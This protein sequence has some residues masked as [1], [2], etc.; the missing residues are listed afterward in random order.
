MLLRLESLAEA[1]S[2]AALR[3][4]RTCSVAQF[5]AGVRFRAAVLFSHVLKKDLSSCLCLYSDVSFHAVELIAAALSVNVAVLLLASPSVTTVNS[6]MDVLGSYHNVIIVADA[7]QR[8]ALLDVSAT[9]F[10]LDA[11]F[12]NS[13]LGR[14]G[15]CCGPDLDFLLQSGVLS[16]VPALPS[17]LAPASLVIVESSGVL[18][19]TSFVQLCEPLLHV[20]LAV[21]PAV[22]VLVPQ[23]ALGRVLG[24]CLIVQTILCGG[25]LLLHEGGAD[26]DVTMPPLESGPSCL[27]LC[28]PGER[29]RNAVEVVISHVSECGSLASLYRVEDH[30]LSGGRTI[31]PVAVIL[32][33]ALRFG[34][35]CSFLY[36]RPHVVTPEHVLLTQWTRNNCT[37]SV[38]LRDAEKL[39][40][41]VFASCSAMTLGSQVP[42]WCAADMVAPKLID[43]SLL[44][45]MVDQGGLCLGSSFQLLQGNAEICEDRCRV[46][47]ARCSEFSVGLFNAILMSPLL[48]LL[49]LE[50]S[51][52]L[53]LPR[54]IGR[55][56]LFLEGVPTRCF[57]KRRSDASFDV[58]AI[59]AS[60]RVVLK[61]ES[62][63]F[64]PLVDPLSVESFAVS[65]SQDRSNGSLLGNRSTTVTL[66]LP[67]RDSPVPLVVADLVAQKQI[68]LKKWGEEKHRGARKG[69]F[70]LVAAQWSNAQGVC[71]RLL[72]W[73]A[74]MV[75]VLTQV[76][77]FPQHA[78]FMGLA[79][80][81]TFV[82]VVDVSSVARVSLEECLVSAKVSF[83]GAESQ[84]LVLRYTTCGPRVRTGARHAWAVVG[85]GSAA[86]A[87]A[88]AAPMALRLDFLV[89]EALGPQ[90]RI[91][92]LCGKS[93][94]RPPSVDAIQA[95]ARDLPSR[96]RGIVVLSV[97]SVFGKKLGDLTCAEYCFGLLPF[98]DNLTCLVCSVV[99]EESLE[100]A[101]TESI[102]RVP[103]WMVE[104]GTLARNDTSSGD[105]G[106]VASFS[107]LSPPFP[108]PLSSSSGQTCFVLGWSSRLASVQFPFLRDGHLWDDA[109]FERFVRP[110]S[111]DFVTV[112]LM[113]VSCEALSG[114]SS[115]SRGACFGPSQESA[116]ILARV[117][118]LD[119]AFG[120]GGCALRSVML[121]CSM[122]R[123]GE[124]QLVLV[125]T[126]CEAAEVSG[127]VWLDKPCRPFDSRTYSACSS[128]GAA[129]LV[130]SLSSSSST[131]HSTVIGIDRFAA[132]QTFRKATL[133]Q[134]CA[135]IATD[136]SGAGDGDAA[137]YAALRRFVVPC[138]SAVLD[139]CKGRFGDTGVNASGLVNLVTAVASLQCKTLRRFHWF[140]ELNPRIESCDRLVIPVEDVSF[141]GS[142]NFRACVQ[143]ASGGSIFQ[144]A[145][146]VSV[147]AEKDKVDAFVCI[148]LSARDDCALQH[149]KSCN[150]DWLKEKGLKELPRDVCL[151]FSM[152]R[153]CCHFA[154]GGSAKALV[155]SVERLQD[156][157]HRSSAQNV[158]VGFSPSVV[159]I[160][161]ALVSEVLALSSGN[162]ATWRF[163]ACSGGTG[164]SMQLLQF[165]VLAFD[166]LSSVVSFEAALNLVGI[167]MGSR[168][169]VS[170]VLQQRRLFLDVVAACEKEDLAKSR[171]SRRVCVL[172]CFAE[173]SLVQ[174]A[175]QQLSKSAAVLC[176]T[177]LGPSCT[178][179]VLRSSRF[180]TEAERACRVV[181]IRC[182]TNKD[183]DSALL[184]MLAQRSSPIQHDVRWPAN[185]SVYDLGSGWNSR[186]HLLGD[187]WTRPGFSPN[188]VVDL[189][190]C[191]GQRHD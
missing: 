138:A 46:P 77:A 139:A 8:D 134:G 149:L 148:S 181:S 161:K 56:Q 176:F 86:D 178:A 58:V 11:G 140:S 29:A 125:A 32:L 73:S 67:E 169:A 50:S 60:A 154:V 80:M 159:G 122:L 165:H 172:E 117:S 157:E 39:Q 126:A 190:D 31:C 53:M 173:L 71:D 82:H 1:A 75:V 23:S 112:N 97:E 163:S 177:L 167:G 72:T 168:N 104:E 94:S 93:L 191:S 189:H 13:L 62:L 35:V 84:S 133:S 136:A 16:E 27:V 2:V 70:L 34:S 174:N 24:L 103:L 25:L 150:S 68:A 114:V 81:S 7:G 52:R 137:E 21:E 41:A 129:A 109:I 20:R 63:V 162:E 156:L 3:D 51:K 36:S 158:W 160:S 166:W 124:V 33:A 132:A 105:L 121:A 185:C 17:I 26:A 90:P 100:A 186:V 171:L 98:R 79:R 95:F 54:Q 101:A 123:C 116:S 147:V 65:Y 143:S 115:V 119:Q 91:V 106:S 42:D 85:R 188:C 38:K 88:R 48:L 89:A 179:V 102:L 184:W 153:P 96:C 18:V 180:A 164:V 55:A 182:C 108:S 175:L 28:E 141:A 120:V 127:R 131:S 43:T 49:L 99:D 74:S 128:D 76:Q 30:G 57:V 19:Q 87:V 113:E 9:T 130:L 110:H 107:H 111:P 183:A 14:M 151:P 152:A 47:L 92:V 69:V 22:K 44:L 78:W 144:V 6:L 187:L 142:P 12:R 83:L 59:D 61:L 4:G 66:L 170:A 15:E 118:G 155:E 40:L 135:W 146:I 5:V 45:R 10:F 145:L 37:V 64:L